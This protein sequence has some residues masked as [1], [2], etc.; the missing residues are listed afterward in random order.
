MRSKQIGSAGEFE[1]KPK[2]PISKSASV[3]MPDD[4]QLDFLWITVW[5]PKSIVGRGL[6]CWVNDMKRRGFAEQNTSRKN[7]A[8]KTNFESNKLTLLNNRSL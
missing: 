5:G 1:V 4:R 3:Q 8:T 6:E 7:K 2:Q